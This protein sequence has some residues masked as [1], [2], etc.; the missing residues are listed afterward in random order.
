[1]D[2]GLFKIKGA[3]YIYI[4]FFYFEQV[5]CPPDTKTANFFRDYTS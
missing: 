3:L 2:L 4:G 1:M 5:I